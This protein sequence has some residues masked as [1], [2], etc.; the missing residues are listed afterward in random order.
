MLAEVSQ[1]IWMLVYGGLLTLLFSGWVALADAWVVLCGGLVQC[2]EEGVWAYE[3]LR[4]QE[5]SDLRVQRGCDIGRWVPS[6]LHPWGGER[7]CVFLC[8]GGKEIVTCGCKGMWYWV[9]NPDLFIC[10]I[11]IYWVTINR[12]VIWPFVGGFLRRRFVERHFRQWV[13]L[14]WKS[15]KADLVR[16]ESW[17]LLL[18]K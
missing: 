16:C 4:C 3:L 14:Y 8:R 11:N 9:L 15:N 7:W 13:F 2:L 12:C 10:N 18:D 17:R 6:F 1:L 5:E